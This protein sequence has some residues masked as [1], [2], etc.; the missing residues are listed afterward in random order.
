MTKGVYTNSGIFLRLRMMTLFII[1]ML[2]CV[3]R[4]YGSFTIHRHHNKDDD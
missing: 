2:L 4:K 3:L 1:I